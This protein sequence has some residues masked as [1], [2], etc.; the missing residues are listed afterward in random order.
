M[1]FVKEAGV[2][3]AFYAVGVLVFLY[4]GAF[5]IT[6]TEYFNHEEDVVIPKHVLEEHATDGVARSTDGSL[7][8]ADVEK[9]KYN[10]EVPKQG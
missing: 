4:L 7:G 2:I 3:F 5:H 10:T 9:E 8:D 6:E 1:P